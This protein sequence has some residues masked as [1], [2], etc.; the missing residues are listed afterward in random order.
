MVEYHVEGF[1]LWTEMYKQY[2]GGNGPDATTVS[3][4][5]LGDY[6]LPYRVNATSKAYAGYNFPKPHYLEPIPISEFLLTGGFANT[7]LYQNPGWPTR[8]D[9]I[10]DYGYDCD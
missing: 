6:M 5:A 8:N 4:K 10:A 2:K 7:P 1:N 3:I 9:G